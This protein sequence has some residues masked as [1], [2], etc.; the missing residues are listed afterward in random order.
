MLRFSMLM[1][2]DTIYRLY[3]FCL[4]SELEDASEES[5]QVCGEKKL[6]KFKICYKIKKKRTELYCSRYK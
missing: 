3:I 5:R 1:I 6:P 2:E 4:I